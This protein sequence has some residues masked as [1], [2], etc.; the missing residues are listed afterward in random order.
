[1]IPVLDQR[2]PETELREALMSQAPT[3]RG[4]ILSVGVTPEPII[5][6]LQQLRPEYVAMV[7]T[8]QSRQKLG[9]VF[10]AHPRPPH[11]VRI[12]TVEDSPE[13]IG[14]L[15]LVVYEL[16][17]WLTQHC[18]V[19]RR[20]IAVDPTPA[21]KWMSAGVTMLASQLGLEMV[22]VDVRFGPQGPIPESMKLIR[23]GN[24]FEQTGFLAAD[25]GRQH[26]NRGQFAAA[27]ESWN[28]IVPIRAQ[29]RLLYQGLAQLARTLHCWDLF[30]HYQHSLQSDFH[31]ALQLLQ[32]YCHSLVGSKEL[33]QFVQQM[34]T[35]AE[36]V[37]Q[38]TSAD[39][40]AIEATADLLANAQRRIA[41]GQYDD[42]CARLYRALE[43]V[44]QFVLRRKYG[45]DVSRPDWTNQPE[46][47]RQAASKVFGETLPEQLALNNAWGLLWSLEDPVARA[48]IFPNSRDNERRFHF[49][50]QPL[51][52]RRNRSI[53]AHGWNA[54]TKTDVVDLAQ[55]VQQ[56][57]TANQPAIGD[58]L[59]KLQV[60]HLPELPLTRPDS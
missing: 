4:L 10:Q 41:Q 28:S 25:R 55:Q 44:A 39:K 2:C 13:N 6:S 23:L 27:A 47:I 30:A 17:R 19:D 12:E 52:D 53:L 54:V 48:I 60:P 46:H 29:E 9:E 43:S 8:P 15:V 57:L 34:E 18:G 7:A 31:Q 37:E 35:L 58:W 49:R 16:Y 24:A 36:A 33:R 14:R 32:S 51:L 38:V 50:F 42:A 11:C 40:P 21:R 45:L 5:F 26:F 1:M 3:T 20:E 56:A 59:A 22:Y